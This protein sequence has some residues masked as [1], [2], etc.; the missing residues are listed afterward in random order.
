MQNDLLG[1]QL[2]VNHSGL[3]FFS[4]S[5]LFFFLLYSLMLFSLKKKNKNPKSFFSALLLKGFRYYTHTQKN[6]QRN[7]EKKKGTTTNKHIPLGI[8]DCFLYS[9]LSPYLYISFPPVACEEI[10]LL[11]TTIYSLFPNQWHKM[12]QPPLIG[13]LC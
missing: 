2:A 9:F 3:I 11:T 7:E 10:T 13:P 5:P 4:F 6:R 1:P 12:I 8:F